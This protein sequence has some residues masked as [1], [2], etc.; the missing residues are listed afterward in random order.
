M[1]AHLILKQHYQLYLCLDIF[2]SSLLSLTIMILCDLLLIFLVDWQLTDGG[3]SLGTIET[4]PFT[5]CLILLCDSELTVI[6]SLSSS[7]SYYISPLGYPTYPWEHFT[8]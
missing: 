1:S 5:M 3:P 6:G 4:Q 8:L 2:L 7:L